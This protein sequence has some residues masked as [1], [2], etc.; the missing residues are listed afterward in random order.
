MTLTKLLRSFL[1][2]SL[3]V[4]ILS[5]VA[6]RYQPPVFTD[7][8]RLQKITATFPVIDQ[9]YKDYAEK[10][11]FP[12][13]V[14]GIVVDGKLV[15]TGSLGYSNI[16]HQTPATTNS[17]FRIASMSKSFTAMAILKLRDEGKLKL[18]DP[19]YLYIPE[20]KNLHY[21][22]RDASPITIRNLLTHS[23]G[24]P[25][26]N[27][28]GD[29]QLAN[30]DEQLLD[31]YRKGISFSNDPGLV[32]EYSNLGFATLGYIIKKVSGQT[33]QAYIAA[34]ILKPLGMTHTY[35]EYSKIPKEKLALGYR[36]LDNEW[37]EQ[38]LLHDGSYGAMG[39]MITTMED[40][41]KYVALHLSAWPPRDDADIGPV[42]RSSIREMHYP[43]DVSSLNV[44]AKTTTGRPCPSVNAYAYGLGWKKDCDGKI[45][46]AHSG[47]LPGFGSHWAILPEYGIGVISF[48]NLTYASAGYADAMALDTLIA[49]SGIK[50]RTL[51]ASDILNTRKAQLIKLLPAWDHPEAT[52][53]FAQNF[54]MDYF[55][56][57]LKTE[58]TAAFDQAGKIRGV[59]DL[60]A[61]NQLR[62]YFVMEGEKA[63]IRVSFTLT[64]ETPALIQEY[65]ISVVPKL[66]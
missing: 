29:R 4:S 48:T 17:D 2:F 8:D 21:L 5:T 50:P 52:G 14:Y 31:L 64:P 46:I 18:D 65:H 37:V 3:S 54:F 35:Y 43:W 32:Y 58:A 45:T 62:G 38:P 34:N 19:A 9:L 16:A 11:H 40:F 22:T 26:D 66:Q 6:Q 55:P 42:K 53:L 7:A 28:W 10:S 61:E 57:K 1:T 30:T 39:G 27:P 25:E 49:L 24:F 41:S 51:P 20:M 47:G 15:H 23:A 60:V 36:W 44:K 13:F 56:D 59:Q 63:N 12:G 33:Y